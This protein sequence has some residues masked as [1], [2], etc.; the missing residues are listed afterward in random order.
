MKLSKPEDDP[1]EP[2][3]DRGDLIRSVLMTDTAVD[4]GRDP[5]PL[6]DAVEEHNQRIRVLEELAEENR[7]LRSRVSQLEQTVES[8]RADLAALYGNEKTTQDGRHAVPMDEGVWVPESV[9]PINPMR[10][11]LDE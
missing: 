8:M 1:N 11:F 7:Q 2:A 4:P 6:I 5:I 3:D 9:N 10:E